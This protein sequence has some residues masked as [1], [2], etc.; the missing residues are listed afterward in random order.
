MGLDYPTNG[1]IARVQKDETPFR[2]LGIGNALNP[3]WS[4]V[5]NLIDVR[6]AD[7]ATRWYQNY[8]LET[9]GEVRVVNLYRLVL[10]PTRQFLDEMEVK[11]VFA[12]KEWLPDADLGLTLL[13]EEGSA[14][15][16]FR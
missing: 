8:F 13:D 3:N 10:M 11:Y 5:Y 4:M 2:I 16:W 15:L 1:L 6:G 9:A 14:K 12:S 7:F